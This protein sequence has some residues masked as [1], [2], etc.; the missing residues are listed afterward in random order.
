MGASQDSTSP[1]GPDIHFPKF[2]PRPV[3]S[4]HKFKFSVAVDFGTD[5]IG[6]HLIY[7]MIFNY[8]QL[9]GILFMI[10][11]SGIRNSREASNQGT[12]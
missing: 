1:V 10:N 11:S 7:K 5:G 8:N 12:R 3:I 9:H 6:I 4:S 2:V